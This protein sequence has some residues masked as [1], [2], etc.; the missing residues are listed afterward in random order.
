MGYGL[1][2][3]LTRLEAHDFYKGYIN[4]SSQSKGK[5][6]VIQQTRSTRVKG[7]QVELSVVLRSCV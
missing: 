4:C 1:F 7:H 6:G 3:Y 5:N 2:K